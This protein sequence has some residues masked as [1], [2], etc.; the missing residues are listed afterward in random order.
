MEVEPILLRLTT[1]CD[2]R[3][4]GL[5]SGIME[6]SHSSTVISSRLRLPGAT[7]ALGLMRAAGARRGSGCEAED[8]AV[9]G[10]S[11]GVTEGIIAAGMTRGVEEARESPIVSALDWSGGGG[12]SLASVGCETRWTLW[13]ND[14]R[15]SKASGPVSLS[16]GLRVPKDRAIEYAGASEEFLDVSEAVEVAECKFRV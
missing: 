11:L 6:G 4:G 2:R 10:V 14:L 13:D 12:A 9:I 8:V 16:S 1:L 5:A 7:E 3:I 15:I